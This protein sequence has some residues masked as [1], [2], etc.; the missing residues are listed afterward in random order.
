[1]KKVLLITVVFLSCNIVN[2]Q[3]FHFLP[4]K[5]FDAGLSSHM[6]V[7]GDFN[8]DGFIDIATANSTGDNISILLAVKADSLSAEVLY[9]AGDGCY[10]IATADFNG[11]GNL[12]IVT[13]NMHD[14]NISVFIGNGDGSFNTQV[15]YI[16]G[17][18]PKGVVCGDFNNDSI[19]DIVVANDY[20]DNISIFTGIGNGTFNSKVDYTAGDRPHDILSFDLDGD[21]CLDVITINRNDHDI[22]VIKGNGD[23]S[24]Q[25]PIWFDV[26]RYPLFATLGYFNAD[27]LIDLAVANTFDCDSISILLGDSFSIFK[28]Y[29]N[30]YVEGIPYGLSAAD[31]DL[32]GFTD[33]AATMNEIDSLYILAGNGDGTFQTPEKYLAGNDPRGIISVDI[34][35]DSDIDIYA[36]N[37]GSGG[38]TYLYINGT[39]PEINFIKQDLSTIGNNDGEA[40]AIVTGGLRPY[41]YQ[42]DDPLLQTDSTATNLTKGVYTL[43]VNDSLGCTVHAEVEILNPVCILEVETSYTHASA[44]GA[45]DGEAIAT[46]LNGVSPYSFQWND[47]LLQIDSIADNLGKGYYQ[48]IVTDS[49]GCI[50][51]SYVHILE[52]PCINE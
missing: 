33:I 37:Y 5:A 19:I 49:L 18:T 9:P 12:D 25:T 24:F 16:A 48:C 3:N 26:E 7:E 43:T 28:P 35:Q 30:I 11:D 15:N 17:N 21:T 2:S 36:V 1:M 31:Y 29:Y 42:W 22:C 51:T 10:D 13:T 40:T 27:S 8:N 38:S 52:L 44:I 20:A 4:F 14:D 23:G 41:L 39:C 50:D 47:P 46:I 45:T 34:D 6:L 32:D